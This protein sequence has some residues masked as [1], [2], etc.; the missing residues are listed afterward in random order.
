MTTYLEQEREK[1]RQQA[2]I[3]PVVLTGCRAYPTTGRPEGPSVEW[4]REA[5]GEWC[6]KCRHRRQ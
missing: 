4:C 5:R 1:E 6:G 3:R 2:A